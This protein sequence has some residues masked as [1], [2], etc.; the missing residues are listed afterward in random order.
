MPG[1]KKNPARGN[2]SPARGQGVKKSRMADSQEPT[3]EHNERSVPSTKFISDTNSNSEPSMESITEESARLFSDSLSES[4][5]K[6]YSRARSVLASFQL[7]YTLEKVRP[8]PVEQLVQFIA[9]LYLKH[10]SAAT[11]RSYI[12]GISFSHKS[13]NLEDITK[14]VIISKMLEGLHRGLYRRNP[15]KDNKAR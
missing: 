1:G 10:L 11:V 14:N 13:L 8:V 5:W 4:T 6:S 2:K 15:Q 12:S 9:Y 3:I 7:Q